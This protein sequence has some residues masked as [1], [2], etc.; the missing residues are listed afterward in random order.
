MGNDAKDD[1]NC[2]PAAKPMKN[3]GN[4]SNIERSMGNDAEE[5][6]NC[7]PAAEP[8]GEVCGGEERGK[9]TDTKPELENVYLTSP[10]EESDLQISLNDTVKKDKSKEIGNDNNVVI[11]EGSVADEG[12]DDKVFEGD[13]N[14]LGLGKD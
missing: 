9:E 2:K 6:D 12:R 3:T 4:E 7:K 1:D 5:Y 14:N 13:D 8:V 10:D 11:E